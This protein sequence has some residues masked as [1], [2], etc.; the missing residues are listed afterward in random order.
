MA[1]IPLGMDLGTTFSAIGK[2]ENSSV[3]I[4]PKLYNFPL[5]NSDSLQ[6]KV[7]VNDTSNKDK[8][9]VG[10]AAVN[11]GRMNP[12]TYYSAFKRGMDENSP[13]PC[14]SNTITPVELSSYIVHEALR[15]VGDVENP[16]AFVPGGFVVSVPYYFK[17]P[18]NRHTDEAVKMAMEKMF[19][20]RSGYSTD[21]FLRLIPEPI[22]AGLSYIMDHPHD[23]KND[24][25]I[26]V[27]DLGGGT[28]DVTIFKVLNDLDG[29]KIKFTVLSTAGDSRLGGEDFDETLMQYI[30]DTE[31]IDINK[32][33]DNDKQ[34]KRILLNLSLACTDCKKQL[35]SVDSYEMVLPF[36]DGRDLERV[37]Q[38]DEFEKCFCGEE[39]NKVDYK[40]K[41]ADIVDE[42]LELAHLVPN[43]IDR[44]VLVGGSSNI[45]IVKR[46]LQRKFGD[47]IFTGD[48][49]GAVAK[50]A[51]LVAAIEMDKKNIAAGREPE[52][53]TLW[54]D[55][56]INDTVA[57]SL[58]IE[59]A[60]G[61][62]DE[63]IRRNAMTPAKAIKFYHPMS[64]T[65]DGEKVKMSPLSICQGKTKVGQVEFPDIYTHGR[66]PQ[67]IIIKV[68][69]VAESTEIRSI[70]IVTEGNADKSDI[71][72]ESTLS[73]SK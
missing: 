24:E 63:V 70:I 7:F 25:I 6:S 33:Q 51:A 34:K 60:N 28:F 73:I 49:Q 17:E 30:L 8:H 54:H 35:S 19:K 14:G 39:G 62:V 36:F 1:K 22:A 50:G 71:I 15:I 41:I 45:P 65:D 66:K 58:G 61:K 29:K 64:L 56:K 31:G 3:H 2:W 55:F 32:V 10:T 57:H 26:F 16:T 42:A 38:R 21:L 43:R 37:I 47:K 48:T 18:Q 13:M 11:K 46:L 12:D 9:I 68:E 27:F 23:V 69:L 59:I 72:L 53:M 20:G 4:G 40:S 52:F 67:D 44:V 5:E